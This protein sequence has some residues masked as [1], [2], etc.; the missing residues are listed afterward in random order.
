[1]AARDLSRSA[2][3]QWAGRATRFSNAAAGYRTGD[4]RVRA[5]AAGDAVREARALVKA[6]HERTASA[7]Q[8]QGRRGGRR[9]AVVTG[10]K[11]AGEAAQLAAARQRLRGPAPASAA[12]AIADAAE[13]ATG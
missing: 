12:E 7:A 6:H 2:R 10:E 13:E 5:Q 9:A 11:L 4:P 3:E 8:T 1:M